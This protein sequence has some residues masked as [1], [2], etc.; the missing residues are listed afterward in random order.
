MA[1]SGTKERLANC[2]EHERKDGELPAL[3]TQCKRFPSHARSRSHLH[4][5]LSMTIFIEGERPEDPEGATNPH[6]HVGIQE[7]YSCCNQVYGQSQ[8]NISRVH[9][10]LSIRNVWPQ[11]VAMMPHCP[12]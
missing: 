5:A 7:R 3:V 12:P 9:L 10:H 2:F 1:S 4:V 6:T 11:Q 8:Q